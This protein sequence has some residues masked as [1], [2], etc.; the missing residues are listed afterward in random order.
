L[1]VFEPAVVTLKL[2]LAELTVVAVPLEVGSLPSVVYVM[3]PTP[4]PVPSSPVIA[5]ETGEL[6]YQPDE[7]AALLHVAELD[8]AVESLCAVNVRLEPVRPA[9][10]VAVIEPVCVVDEAL[11]V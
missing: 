10:F 11:N 1:I 2:A 6:V 3:L 4:E 8:G 5:T 9:L 7:Q